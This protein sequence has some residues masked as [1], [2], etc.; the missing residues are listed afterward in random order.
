MD[1][2]VNKPDDIESLLKQMDED[3]N[4]LTLVGGTLADG[5]EHYAY[6]SIPPSKYEAFRAAEAKGNYNLADFG[7]ILFHADGREP[8]AQ[9]MKDMEEKYGANHR[10]EEELETMT[11]RIESAISGNQSGNS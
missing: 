7:K 4:I 10:F 3:V 9:V 1:A 11:K 6:V 8:S 5:R 2:C